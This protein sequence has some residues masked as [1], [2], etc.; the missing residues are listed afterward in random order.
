MSKTTANDFAAKYVNLAS[1]KFGARVTYATDDFFAAKERLI[2]DAEPISKLG[3]FDDHGQWMDGWESRRRRGGGYDHALINLWSG[4]KIEAVNIDTSF[5]TGNQPTA[6][7]I[8]ACLSDGTPA[9][10]AV[11]TEIVGETILKPNAEH[12]IEVADEKAYNWLRLNMFPDGGIARL[13]IYGTPFCDWENRNKSA[14]YE[15]SALKNA[16]RIITYND[17]HYGSVWS[18]LAEGRGT[19]MGDGWETRRRRE[20]G[21]DWIV[22]K[23]GHSGTIEKIE[24]DTAHYKGNYP[25]GFSLEAAYGKDEAAE[26]LD[27]DALT[28]KELLPRQKL[29]AD[30]QHFF[31]GAAIKGIGPISYVRMTIYPD[32]GVSRLRLWGKLASDD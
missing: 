20:P 32:G 22:I 3:V 28:W 24:L 17:A 27:L 21:N 26:G 30:T 1:A 6:A 4:G 31:E 16:G 8:E 23:L 13:R 25:D 18:L 5:F 15:L 9:D 14:L 12:L 10:D 2:E 29:N 11:W 19:N 7:S